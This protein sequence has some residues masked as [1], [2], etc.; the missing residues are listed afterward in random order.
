MLHHLR[1]QIQGE[2]GQVQRLAAKGDLGGVTTLRRM[3][4][5][6]EGTQRS[7]VGRSD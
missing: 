4:R 6:R 5:L 1:R 2:C 7:L 3:Q